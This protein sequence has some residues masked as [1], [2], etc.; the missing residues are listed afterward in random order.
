MLFP[1]KGISGVERGRGSRTAGVFP[2]DFSGQRVRILGGQCGHP[3]SVARGVVPRHPDHCF[4]VS[5]TKIEFA[6][7]TTMK[8]VVFFVLRVGDFGGL[9]VKG[10]QFL[11]GEGAFVGIAVVSVGL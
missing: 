3:L 10:P 6:T 11:V 4:V 7:Q 9:K 2:F 5:N 8:G 1:R